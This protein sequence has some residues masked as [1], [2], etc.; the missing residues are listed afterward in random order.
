MKRKKLFMLLHSSNTKMANIRTPIELSL[1]TTTA[2][3]LFCYKEWWRRISYTYLVH[4]EYVARKLAAAHKN[5]VLKS[6]KGIVNYL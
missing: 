3:F 5:I 6:G 4:N 1:N 2:N